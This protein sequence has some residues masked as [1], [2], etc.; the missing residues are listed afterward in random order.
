MTPKEAIKELKEEMEVFKASI[1]PKLLKHPDAELKKVL[2][3]NDLAIKAL[4]Q[5]C[6]KLIK[7]IPKD[8]AYDTETEDILVYRNKYT[9]HEI[10][11]E[12][13]E[14]RYILE[15]QP[16]RCDSCTHSKEQDGSNCY[17]CVKD[18]VDN[19][20]A[21]P[22]DEMRMMDEEIVNKFQRGLTLTVKES[23][24]LFNK[25]IESLEQQPYEDCISRAEAIRIA[26]QGQ[27]QGYEWQFKK[28]CNLPSVTP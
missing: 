6:C 16:N 22:S 2:E 18:M 5:Q 8:Y 12:K 17:E 9:G 21:Q 13:P 24:R 14:P 28:L 19:F 3:A 20:E 7:E 11:V 23:L 25:Y 4:E 1:D 15:Q 10:H 26:E 27:I